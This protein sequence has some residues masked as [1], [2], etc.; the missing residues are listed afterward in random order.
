MPHKFNTS[1]RHKFAKKKYRVTNWC[2]YNESLRNRGDLTV[3]ITGDARK[4]WAAPRRRSRG[5]QPRYSDLAITMCLT[6]GMVYRLPLRQT[7]GLIRSI[8]KLMLLEISVPDFSTL[9]RRGRGLSLPARPKIKITDP[10][11]LAIDSTGLKVFDEGEWLQS[12]YNVKAKRKRWRKLHLGLN[13]VTGDI[14]CSD[15]TLDD[16]GDPTVLPDLLNQIGTPVSR[17]I[18]DGAYDGAPTSDLLK[19]RF[20]EAVEIIIPPPKNA[21]PSPQSKCFPSLRDRHIVKIQTHGRMA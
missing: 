6:L 7:Q 15:L 2:G 17:F 3:W 4:H 1:R 9:S 18:A 21:I 14:V 20:G 13:L 12:K 11:H 8:S 10:V 16:V 5:S 19:A